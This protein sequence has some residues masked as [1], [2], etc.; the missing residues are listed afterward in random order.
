MNIRQ[1]LYI[2]GGGMV[3]RTVTG[4]KGRS[5]AIIDP[6]TRCRSAII[7]M[8]AAGFSVRDI[9]HQLNKSRIFVLRTLV[10]NQ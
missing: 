8:Y 2:A 10:S 7:G 4:R 6:N 9:A 1:H 5:T 3:R